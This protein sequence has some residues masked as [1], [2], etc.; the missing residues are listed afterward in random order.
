MSAALAAIRLLACDVDGVLTDGRLRYGA[1]GE[2]DKTFDV[3]DG[4]GLRRLLDAGVEVAWITA[5]GGPAVELRARELGVRH[6]RT[7][8]RDKGTALAELAAALAIEPA[9]I[10]YVGD[11]L[12][13]L[14]ALRAAGLAI[15]PAD[16]QPEV[17]A[18]AAWVT[19]AAG[20]RG[21]V[22]EVCDAILAARDELAFRVVIPARMAATRLP[23]K[24][25][26]LLAGRPMIAYVWER[27]REAGA[28][29]IVVATDDARIDEVIAGLGGRALATRP[30]HPSGSDRVYEVVARLGW[31]DDAIVV[32]LQGD[33]PAMPAAAIRRGAALLAAT[34]GAHVATLAAPITAPRDLFDPD[35]VKVVRDD[36]G[37]AR[38]FS[39]APIPW[40]RGAFAPGAVPEALPAGAPFLRHLGIY[41]YRAAAL[42][43]LCATPPHPWERAESLEQLRALAIGMAIAVG[44][45]DD[46]PAHGVDTEADLARVEALLGAGGR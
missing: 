23:G 46:A 8:R 3:R 9:A 34:P 6:V 45:V 24:P 26:R 28:A 19:R 25:L 42:G 27:A 18:Q 12:I 22:R 43:R 5:R 21:A 31:P 14:P 17:R 36:A 32:N 1:D 2:L 37:L 29:E 35:V 44:V 16:A 30:D 11:D 39:R 40:V 13:D 7:G 4:H 20:G 38:A 15:A 41:A 33:E 10:A